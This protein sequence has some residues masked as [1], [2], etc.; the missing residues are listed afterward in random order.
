VTQDF[1]RKI[2]DFVC[3]H[4]G[5]Q[6]SGNGYTNHC[7]ACLWSRHVDESPG[8]RAEHCLGLMR[9]E[10]VILEKGEYIISHVC[11]ACGAKR[12]VKSSPSD[13]ISGYL[14]GMLE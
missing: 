1:R 11:E 13:D 9:P 8:D 6:V 12:R 14:A 5:E 2:E 3:G 7:P 10:S 4:C